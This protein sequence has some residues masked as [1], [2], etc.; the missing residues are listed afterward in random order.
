MIPLDI[1]IGAD[2]VESFLSLDYNDEPVDLTGATFVCKLRPSLKSDQ[3]AASLDGDVVD[4][5]SGILKLTLG[6]AATALLQPGSG[7][8]DLEITLEGLVFHAASGT[9]RILERASR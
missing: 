3:V 9:Y 4:G 1:H 8:W 7:V 5:P 6:A 2:F